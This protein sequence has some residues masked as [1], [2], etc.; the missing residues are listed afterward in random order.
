M[1]DSSCESREN[2]IYRCAARL[3][4]RG[5][6][7]EAKPAGHARTLVP[8]DTKRS[9]PAYASPQA[10]GRTILIRAAG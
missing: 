3:P 2:T 9:K 1:P 10:R 4:Q 7:S 5:D 8:G 6:E